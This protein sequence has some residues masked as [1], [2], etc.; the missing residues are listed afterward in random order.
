M[1]EGGSGYALLGESVPFYYL[2]ING[3]VPYA[4]ETAG[5]L[6]PDL[7]KTKLKWLEYG[8]VPYFLLSAQNSE[9]LT[10]TTAEALF[11]TGYADQKASAAARFAGMGGPAGQPEGP[12][13]V[14]G[15][16]GRRRIWPSAPTAAEPGFW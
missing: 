7:Q 15:M 11:S 13:A 4:L 9:K 12:A 3:S 2:V 16:S 14:P 1:P 10:D 8:A 5:N 6:S